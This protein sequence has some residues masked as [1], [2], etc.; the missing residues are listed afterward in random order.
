MEDSAWKSYFQCFWG[1]PISIFFYTVKWIKIE[2]RLFGTREEDRRWNREY[3]EKLSKNWSDWK[4]SIFF[5]STFF[6]LN[7][8]D[9]WC[10]EI[11]EIKWKNR[12]ISDFNYTSQFHLIVIPFFPPSFRHLYSTSS[13]PFLPSFLPN[14]FASSL[15]LFPL[16]VST[17]SFLTQK[18]HSS[19][20]YFLH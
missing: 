17:S 19:L 4:L 18:N 14:Y 12:K 20:G 10:F 1:F 5:N 13:I 8:I 6:Q 7:R 16:S 2:Y 15:P 3:Y 11:E 9:W